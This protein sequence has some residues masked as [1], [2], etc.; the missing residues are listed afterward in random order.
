MS[1][2]KQKVSFSSKFGSLFSVMRD[3]SSVLF[4]LKLYMILTKG[5]HQSAKFQTF[6]CSRE[7]SPSSYHDRL[8]LLKVYNISAKKVQR[9]YVSW[10]RR[11]MQNL[12]KNR[13]VVSKMTRIWWNM[14]RALKSLQNLHFDWSLSRKV[15]N[16]SP[17]KVQR[18]CLSWLWRVMQHLKKNWLVVWKMTRGIWQIFTRTLEIVKIGTF[19]GSFCPK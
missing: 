15:N 13:F 18:S 4:Y 10:H 17:K 2:F 6:D 7:I 1:F 11:A 8:L 9:S 12:K 19:M 16:F 3:N 14:I 5:V